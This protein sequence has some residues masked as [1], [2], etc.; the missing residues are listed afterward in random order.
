MRQGLGVA[1]V[2]V[3]V[4]LAACSSRPEAPEAKPMKAE[5]TK[6]VEVALTS[7][8]FTTSISGKE[9]RMVEL[10]IDACREMDA[11]FWK[12]SYGDKAALLASIAEPELRRFAEINYGP[13]DRLNANA[14][15][16]PASAP[17]PKG[18]VTTRPT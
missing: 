3:T 14:P 12:E 5:T 1:A 11:I 10:L 16:L 18:R 7:D 4:G 13:W 15:F 8:L 2:V 9:R 17:S 6:Y